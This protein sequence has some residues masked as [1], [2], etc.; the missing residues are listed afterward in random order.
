M[1]WYS[2]LFQNFPQFIVI[3]T[4]KGFDIVNKAEIDVILELSCFFHDPADVG[5]LISGS[6]ASIRFCQFL[7]GF[8]FCRFYSHRCFLCCFHYL[9][10]FPGGSD[11]KGSACN[12]G[13]LGLIPESGTSPG[14]GNGSPFQY[15]CLE[16][17]TDRGAWRAAVC[18][19]A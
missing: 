16:N 12:A 17:Y 8:V 1:V 2:H 18:G 19:V 4:V 14:E 6:S 5:N 9:E 7:L 3:H 13:D 11:G 15:S 10:G